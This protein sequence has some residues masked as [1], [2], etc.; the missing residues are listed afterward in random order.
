MT[1]TISSLSGAVLTTESER[2]PF[3]SIYDRLNAVMAEVGAV[4][5]DDRNAQQ[6]F[7]FR[8]IDAVVNAVYPALVRHGVIV[9]PNVTSSDY[10]SI[11]VGQ[12]RTPMGH[13]RVKVNYTF[14]GQGGDSITASVVAEAMDSGDKAT[15]KAMSV[16]L[17][18][19]LLQTLMLPTDEPDPDSQVY[20]R[21]P[22]MTEAEVGSRL[23]AAAQ[24]FDTDVETLTSKFRAENGDLSMAQFNLQPIEVRTQFLLD[25]ERY[26]ARR[27]AQQ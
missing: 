7:N 3:I 4:S 21:A 10:S 27:Q 8:G 20:D 16:A 14:V 19:A 12:K 25:V 1:E 6:G 13:C 18:T 15:P 24:I 26:A 2:D 9:V 5:K 22:T 17:R 23:L 11:E